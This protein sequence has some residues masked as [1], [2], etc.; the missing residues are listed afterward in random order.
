MKVVFI[1]PMFNAAPHV[2]ELV[3][4]LKS[5]T[6]P[7]WEAVL[8]DDMSNDDT[9]FMANHCTGND[10]RFSV[11]VNKE[12]KWALKNVVDN[13][14]NVNLKNIIA[15]LD[16]DDYICNKNT[17]QLI[18]D[19][20]QDDDVDTVWTA[21]KWDINNIN[22]SKPFPPDTNINPYE[23]PWIT[24][25]LKTFRAKLIHQIHDD[26]FRDMYGDWFRRGYDQALYLPLLYLSKKRKYIDEVCYLY[27]INSNSMK[28][29]EWKEQDQLKTV[30]LVRARGYIK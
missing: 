25:H 30:K 27:R 6:N 9:I 26:N 2:K 18:I 11:I 5:Q 1:V 19:A 22:I 21:H 12:K 17:V 13:S 20:Y 24:S 28:H 15:V 10:E 8:I 16:G 14:R 3:E 4:S 23:Y 29:R 7:N